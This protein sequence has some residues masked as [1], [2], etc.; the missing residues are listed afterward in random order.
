MIGLAVLIAASV[1]VFGGLPFGR[2]LLS[3]YFLN[4]LGQLAAFAVLAVS[5]DLIWGYLGILSLGHGLFFAIG[6]YVM[7]M[8]LL[9]HSFQVTGIVPDFMQFMGWKEFPVYWFGFENPVFALAV[10]LAVALAVAGIFG[11]FSFRSRV[12]GVYF[13]IIT[14]ALVYVAMLLMFRNDTGFGGNN[15]ITGFAYIFGLPLAS[16]SVISGITIISFVVLAVV[17]IGLK[18]LAGSATGRLML[19]CR[20]DE[21]R[22]RTLGYETGR[23]KLKIWCLSALIAAIAGFL[24]VPQV[25]IINPRVLAPELSLEIAVWVAIGGR[26]RLAGAV[27]GAF[28]INAL[29]FWMSTKAPDL[30]PFIL[31]S[32][33]I[34]VAALLPN[35]L[36][37][38]TD[39]RWSGQGGARAHALRLWGRWQVDGLNVRFGSFQA[40]NN[41]SLAVDYGEVRAII[42][43]NG[44]GKTTLLDVIS[45]ITTCM[46]GSVTLDGLTDLTKLSEAAV[47][48]A[49]VRR[50]F[51]KPSVFEALTIA[52]NIMVGLSAPGALPRKSDGSALPIDQIL[53]MVG[54]ADVQNRLAGELAHGQK[55]WLEIG[56]VLAGNPKILM[57]DEPVAGLTDEETEKTAALIGRLKSFDR[58]IIVVEHDM[59]FVGQIADRVTVLHEGCTLFEGRMAQA[60]LDERHYDSAQV[61]RSVS[62]ELRQGE[63]MVVLGRNGAGKSTLL[64]CIAGV[65]KVSSGDITFDQASVR[66]WAP[67]QRSKAG[68]AYVPQGREIFSELSVGEN[69]LAAARAHGH[70]KDGAIDEVLKIFPVIG[71]MWTPKSMVWGYLDATSKPVLEISSGD[72]VKLSSFP[73]GGMETLPPDGLNIPANYLEALNTLEQSGGPH[74][75]TGPVY[76]RNAKPGDTLQIDILDVQ[77]TMDWGFVAIMPLLGTLPEEFTDYETIHPA[78]DHEKNVA[79]MPWGTEI[80]LEPFF[81]IMGVAPPPAWGRC[82]SP[83]PR[84][85]G[86]NMDNKE[87]KGDGEVCITALE[88]GVTGTF[89]LTVRK[90]MNI[91]TPFAENET[92]LI[93]IGLDED[94][95]DAAK[96][97]VRE[98]VKHVCAR[99]RLTRNQAYMLCSLAGNLRVTQTVDGN[100]GI[101]MISKIKLVSCVFLYDEIFDL[102][103]LAETGTP[104][105]TICA[106][107]HI[108]SRTFYR[109]KSRYGL[110]SPAAFKRLRTLEDE[111]RHLRQILAQ[112]T[113]KAFGTISSAFIR[114]P[115]VSSPHIRMNDVADVSNPRT[116]FRV[117]GAYRTCRRVQ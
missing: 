25:G 96:Q 90:D 51:Q 80:A 44:A 8:H 16:I 86:G 49:G 117:A 74:F 2:D 105:E 97:A 14:Q 38:L 88:T 39:L 50:K 116:S 58:A 5:L 106:Q 76:V 78:I 100:K 77:C 73:A 26:G 3:S 82:G 33:M 40:L 15:G 48:R 10:G 70:E 42:G 45:G 1:A 91:D 13:S 102:L 62:L 89:R 68:L 7:A 30:W 35:G 92:H 43:P 11:F 47:A 64:K 110:L 103:Q 59:D 71:D 99:S 24:Y 54:L 53:E 34:V 114:S 81:G 57:L 4:S 98:M 66:S 6:G 69:I 67:Y 17:L 18:V 104:I 27:M 113:G 112:M 56:I 79:I 12:S 9:K 36:L 109:W 108:S 60:R 19:A 21:V 29:K 107:A 23:L 65:L 22:L 87:L 101:H 83:V 85:F 61:L 84:S 41:L 55:Q 75:I 111:N 72:T 52:E 95:D 63:C 28:L 37:N 46:S 93:S 31:A 94:L 20:D 32:L 115:E